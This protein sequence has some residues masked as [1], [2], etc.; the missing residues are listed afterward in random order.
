MRKDDRS[1]LVGSIFVVVILFII[2]LRLGLRKKQHHRWDLSDRYSLAAGCVLLGLFPT[3]AIEI[4]WGTVISDPLGTLEYDLSQAEMRHMVI[5]SKLTLA[6]RLAWILLAVSFAV[7]Q[8]VTFTECH[9]FH[10]YWE[11]YPSSYS[12]CAYATKQL[13]V[14]VILNLLADAVLFILPMPW[15]F[16]VKRTAREKW[17]LVALFSI[18][19]IIVPI[20]ILRLPLAPESTTL[21]SRLIMGYIE[22]LLECLVANIPTL[23]GLFHLRRSSVDFPDS[24]SQ[25]STLN[26]YGRDSGLAVFEQG[27][28]TEAAQKGFPTLSKKEVK[29]GKFNAEL[30]ERFGS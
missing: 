30:K 24:I 7:I 4:A 17:G 1:A 14:L 19:V 2:A 13:Y 26:G 22:G 20:E 28:Q 25:D 5:A 21:H 16:K 18:H 10:K 9:P 12:H 11:I 27:P 23:Y 15:I 8:V 29:A 6:T 3:I